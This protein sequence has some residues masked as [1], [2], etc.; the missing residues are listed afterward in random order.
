M[1][2]IFIFI[3]LLA[4]HVIGQ[5]SNEQ[6][7]TYIAIYKNEIPGST[8][9]RM[10]LINDSPI[11]SLDHVLVTGITYE[12]SREDGLPEGETF[13]LLHEIADELNELISK[14]TNALLVGSFTHN[15]ERLEYYYL[16]EPKGLKEK[17]D[18][19]YKTKYPNTKYYINI[20]EDNGWS[21]YNDF[22]YPNEE[23]RNYM[24]DQSV[25]SNLEE[26]GDK[27][28]KKRRVSHWLYFSTQKD[29]K[30]CKIE[31]L[32]M[33]FN[34]QNSGVNKKSTLPYE[35]Q[36]WRIDLVDINSIYP[37]TSSL[38]KIAKENHGEYDGWE[39]SVEK[40]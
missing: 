15:K 16:K 23:T 10:D 29:L 31:L 12:T 18:T 21:Y 33:D 13:A 19:F 34:I 8:T 3:F 35:L 25:V 38:R 4:N 6:W 30:N 17:L 20:K 9:I 27:L 11:E 28:T 24:G 7:G 1:T 39:T 22:L 26:A 36:I 37:I 14:E 40:E 32:K 2:K 5:T